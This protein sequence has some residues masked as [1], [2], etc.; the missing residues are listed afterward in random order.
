[1]FRRQFLSSLALTPLA[2]AKDN[3]GLSR[4]AVLT[5][6]VGKSPAEAIAFAKQYGVSWVELRSV[7][8]GKGHYIRQPEADLKQAAKEFADNGLKV[9][10]LNTGFS[11]LRCR[12]VKPYFETQALRPAKL[13][14]LNI[15]EFTAGRRLTESDC[16]RAH[17]QCRQDAGFYVS[18]VADPATVFLRLPMF[19]AMA[20]ITSKEKSSC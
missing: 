19:W 17:F 9:S 10:F 16:R 8:G 20:E 13:A 18:R 15:K 11:K 2:F 5:D 1:M 4:I 12:E 3:I 14:S 6:E 7:P